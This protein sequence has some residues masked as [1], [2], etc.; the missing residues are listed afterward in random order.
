MA[1][2]AKAGHSFVAGPVYSLVSGRTVN[3]INKT[4]TVYSSSF[5]QTGNPVARTYAAVRWRFSTGSFIF[6]YLTGAVSPSPSI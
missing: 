2:W 5:A 6:F 4:K 1:G 3:H